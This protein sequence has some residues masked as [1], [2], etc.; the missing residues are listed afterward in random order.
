MGK[1]LT[2]I[3]DKLI[4]P[5]PD[6]N[7]NRIHIYKNHLGEVTIHFRNFKIVLLTPEEIREWSQGFGVA[8]DNFKRSNYF[9]ND[10]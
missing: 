6:R 5:V 2:T 8:L 9:K 10:I 7:P 3:E 1:I 4:L